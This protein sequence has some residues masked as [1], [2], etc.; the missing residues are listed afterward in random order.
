MFARPA[1]DPRQRA[2]VGGRFAG[3]RRADRRQCAVAGDAAH[4]AQRPKPVD[5]TA[6]RSRSRRKPRRCRSRCRNRAARIGPTPPQPQAQDF[7]PVPDTR[8]RRP[9]STSPRRSPAERGQG[10]EE[11]RRQEQIDLTEH[12]APAGSREAAAPGADGARAAASSWPTIRKQRA[13][14]SREAQ[15]GRSSA[16]SR[17]PTPARGQRR[18]TAGSIAPVR[19]RATTAPTPG[20]QARY[21]AALQEAILSKWTRP[22]TVPLGAALPL[23]D[24][25]VARR[26]R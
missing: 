18:P 16:C 2:G 7:I 14:A 8:T 10:Q 19:R 13:K 24:P 1:V 23:H 22:E 15:A 17:S 26:R 11:K 4:A 12:E 5:E 9:W 21:A 25:P 6:S 3:R 20:L